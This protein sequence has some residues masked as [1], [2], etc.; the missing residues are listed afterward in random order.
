MHRLRTAIEIARTDP[1]T[2]V[3]GNL[4]SDLEPLMASAP[5]DGTLV[6]FHTA[7]LGY[8]SDKA[9][10][11]HFSQTMRSSRAIWISNGLAYS[12]PSPRVYCRPDARDSSL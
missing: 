10:R 12:R 4:L 7:V 9:K 5:K 11:D 2:I 3:R 6:V 1:P 8:V